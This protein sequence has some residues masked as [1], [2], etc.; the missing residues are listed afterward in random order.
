MKSVKSSKLEPLKNTQIVPKVLIM[1]L[2]GF[3][4]LQLRIGDTVCY[5]FMPD[6]DDRDDGDGDG[7]IIRISYLGL[8]S[9]YNVINAYDFGLAAAEVRCLCNCPGGANTCDANTQRWVKELRAASTRSAVTVV[10]Y[11]HHRGNAMLC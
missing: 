9:V 1:P 3:T 6:D 7:G 8:S 2:S 10:K 4:Q 5:R 11:R